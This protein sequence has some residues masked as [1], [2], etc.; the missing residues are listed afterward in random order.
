[1]PRYRILAGVS[2]KHVMSWSV[3]NPRAHRSPA[4]AH[5]LCCFEQVSLLFSE[6]LTTPQP[7]PKA[8]FQS[9]Y[10]GAP[11]RQP[12]LRFRRTH[13]SLRGGVRR[14]ESNQQAYPNRLGRPERSGPLSLGNDSI[15]QRS[16]GPR[17]G[18]R[19]RRTRRQVLPRLQYRAS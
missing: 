17:M 7:S 3:C 15:V 12:F 19:A 11:L 16:L 2:E 10:R 18:S 1:M 6:I 4:Y 5:V 13:Q 9:R 8:V 14:R